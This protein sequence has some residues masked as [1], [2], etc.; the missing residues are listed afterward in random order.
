MLFLLFLRE[1]W[2][3][4]SACLSDPDPLYSGG[5]LTELRGEDMLPEHEIP[6]RKRG[7]AF[8]GE[9]DRPE[10]GKDL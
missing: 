5:D 3:R 9:D 10:H 7:A 8:S 2:S 6:E 1:L 4:R